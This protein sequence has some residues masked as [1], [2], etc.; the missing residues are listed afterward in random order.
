M[1]AVKLV[2]VLCCAIG[3]SS[4]AHAGGFFRRLPEVGEWAKYDLVMLAVIN[5]KD[6]DVVLPEMP[7]MT[8]QLT[9]KCV[10]EEEVDEA[11]HLWLEARIDVVDPDG[12]EHWMVVKLLVPE[13]Q[14]IDGDLSEHIIRGWTVRDD[15][16][17]KEFALD[18]QT[19]NEDPGWF[20]MMVAFPSSESSNGRRQNKTITIDGEDVQLTYNES[21]TLPT[22]EFDDVSLSGEAIWW[23]SEGH[24]FGVAAAE[25]LW[26][27]EMHQPI[28]IEME[29]AMQ[30]DLVETGID[31][32]SD[33]PENH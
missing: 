23:P 6:A 8:G 11:P 1:R 22:R 4:L 21:G 12:A 29:Y 32:E 3:Y 27:Y 18:P 2:C 17:V 7:E 14:V 24:A 30:M 28:E 20:S 5:V 13:D 25:Q 19:L 9:L 26:A 33:M 31:A 10:G 15:I 16:D